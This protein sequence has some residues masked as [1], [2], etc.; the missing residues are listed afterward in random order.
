MGSLVKNYTENLSGSYKA[1]WAFNFYAND[2]SV[3]GNSFSVDPITATAKYVYS[4]KNV[5]ETSVSGYYTVNGDDYYFGYSTP[6]GGQ[7]WAS[8]STVTLPITES[9]SFNTSD[10]FNSSNPTVRSIGVPYT[11]D[12]IYGYSNKGSIGAGNMGNGF[13][14]SSE[15]TATLRNITL[16]VP[17]TATV[18]T[19][20][21]DTGYIYSGLTTASITVS[22]STAYYGGNI[23]SVEFTIGSQTD[24]AAGDGTLSIALANPGTFTPTVTI[25]DSRGQTK[26]Y[27]LDPITVNTYTAPTLSFDVDRTDSTGTPD[28]EG[29]YGLIEATLTFSDVVADAVA[30]SVV[31]TDENGT[32]TTPIVTWYTDNTLQTTVTWANVSSGDTVYGLF[33][34]LNTNYSYSVSVRPRDSQ[35]TGTAITQTISSAFYTIDFLAGGHGIA[36]GKPASATGFECAMEAAFENTV[37]VDGVLSC[38]NDVLIDLPNYQTSGTTDYDIYTAIVALG[39]DSEV[40]V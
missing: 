24:T 36:F 22:D 35:G 39:W 28:D 27:S 14:D 34:G 10:L 30:P 5:A 8:G 16:N 7:S 33:S 19:L 20:S 6:V 29:T 1:V 25:T 26:T 4:G 9:N 11:F 32:Q 37:D 18:S 40:I 15:F 17:P 3:T 21:F 2:I 23:S 13:S 12:Y 38:N 31:V